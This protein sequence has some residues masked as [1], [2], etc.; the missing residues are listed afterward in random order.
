[1]CPYWTKSKRWK[2]S[3]DRNIIF[4]IGWGI[5]DKKLAHSGNDLASFD[6]TRFDMNT[7]YDCYDL[8]FDSI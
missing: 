3:R 6:K 7:Y 8:F 5:T 1:M 2:Y 4:L